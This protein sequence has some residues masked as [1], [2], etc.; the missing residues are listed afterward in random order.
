MI[1]YAGVAYALA[2]EAFGYLKDGKE[3]IDTLKGAADT[4]TEIK[5][6]YQIKDADSKLVDIEW[7]KT[8]GFGKEAEAAGYKIRWSEPDKV[9]SRKLDGYEI[10]YEINEKERTR[11]KIVLRDGLILI[12]KKA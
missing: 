7:P 6:H 10:M 12:G 5:G 2:K 9:A 8:S 4:A 11:R 1:E 3:V